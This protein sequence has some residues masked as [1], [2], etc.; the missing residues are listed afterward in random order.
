MPS[1]AVKQRVD[2]IVLANDEVCYVGEPIALV[3]ADS[4]QIAEDAVALV[5]LDIEHL[6]AVTNPTAGLAIGSARARSECS[7]NLVARME[8]GFGAVDNAFAAAAHRISASFKLNKGGGHS[9]EPR[10]VVAKFDPID[11]VLKVWSSTQRPHHIRSVLVTSLGL[12][13]HEVEVKAPDVGGGFGPKAVF[14][15]EEL[16]IPAAALSLGRPIK[17]IEDRLES[18]TATTQEH[19]QDWDVEAAFDSTGKLLGFRGSVRHDHGACTPYGVQLPYNSATNLIGPYALPAYRLEIS[20]CLTNKVPATPTR[21]AG[22]PQG[23][24]VMEM[25]LDRAARAIGIGRDE[26]RRRN[27]IGPDQMP[28]EIPLV[29]RDGT[30]M[31]YDSGDYPKCQQMALDAI[32]WDSFERRR[33]AAVSRGVMLGIGLANYVEGTGRG[34]FEN[35]QL[36]IGPSGKIVVSTG[37]TAQGQG[38]KTMLAQIVGEVLNVR[39]DHIHVIDGDTRATPHGHG[40]FASRQTVTAGSSA[41]QAA[42]Q[43]R[44]KAKA[45]TANLLEVSADD[46]ELIDGTVQIVGAPGSG[47]TLGEIAR[48]LDGQPGYSL[49]ANLAPGLDA[50]VN[51]QPKTITHCNGTHAVEVEVDPKYWT[52][53]INRYVVIHDCGRM[54]NP[55]MVDGQ[56]IG[57]V[58][59]GIGATLLEWM[60]FDEDGQPQ[61]VTYADYLLPSAHVVPRI[62]VRHLET[63]SPLN[64]LGVKGA[65]E[66]GTIGAP[67]AITSAVEDA[68]CALDV[69]ISE[70]PV[71]PSTLFALVSDQTRPR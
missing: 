30:T 44:D 26:I 57:A 50:E 2:P 67:A 69:R 27:M 3:V 29:M 70:L 58:A 43:V 54:I 11:G 35:V 42:M 61:T 12:S 56:I 62:E 51:F 46:L 66:G 19:I 10:G 22:R 8:V 16:A 1:A 17:W 31:T 63:P 23:T 59:N 25:M 15:P 55:M 40:A 64:P 13:E 24:F 48:I 6:P 18:F 28:Y 32:E 21:G 7:D 65:G 14:H 41:Y 49:P 5:E 4:R 60:R 33:T 9:I 20:I 37:A 38:T 52:V 34:P 45:L 71:T 36:R 39:P 68:L 47:K 53:K